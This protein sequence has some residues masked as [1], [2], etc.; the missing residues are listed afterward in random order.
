MN[1]LPYYKRYP[2]DF[3]EGTVGMP[4]EIKAAYGLL[5]DL[6]Y[7]QGGQ[8]PDNDRYIAGLLGLSVR[9]WNGIRLELISRG[10]I[11]VNGASIS[12]YRAIIELETLRSHQDKQSENARQPMKNKGLRQPNASHTEPDNRIEKTNV[13]SERASAPK[14]SRQQKIEEGFLKCVNS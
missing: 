12:N 5:L 9:K 1:G 13:F 14:K 4:F 2:R 3:I 6:I 7:M 8:L 10:K 11:S